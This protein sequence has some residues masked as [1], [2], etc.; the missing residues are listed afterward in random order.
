MQLP[1]C[2]E[3]VRRG[4]SALAGETPSPFRVQC[5]SV[6]INIVILV[7]C[8]EPKEGWAEAEKGIATGQLN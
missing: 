6:C 7:L 1:N 2:Q 5:S 4:V 3:E 8:S